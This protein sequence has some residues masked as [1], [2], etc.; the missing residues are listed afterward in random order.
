M[1]RLTNLLLW[2]V[3]TDK[4]VREI[5]KKFDKDKSPEWYEIKGPNPYLKPKSEWTEEMFENLRK[6]KEKYPELYD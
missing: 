5:I 1:D 4:E 3:E 6:F 2:G